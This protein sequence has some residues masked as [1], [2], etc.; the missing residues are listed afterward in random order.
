M[1]DDLAAP[2]TD[3]ARSAV[4]ERR[5][6][7][8]LVCLVG[9]VIVIAA[10][11]LLFGASSRST[12]SG[13]IEGAIETATEYFQLQGVNVDL[14]SINAERSL[15]DQYWVRFEADPV[16]SQSPPRE[17]G[18]EQFANHHWSV[19]VVGSSHVGCANATGSPPVPSE[20]IVGFGDR[21]GATP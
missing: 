9:T 7:L 6:I 19:I 12:P 15:V 20:V 13:S 4:R 21:C 16:T 5:T 2:S 17:Y 10:G 1:S 18:Y 14:L 3:A 11:T 8:L